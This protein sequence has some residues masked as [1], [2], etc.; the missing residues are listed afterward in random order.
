MIKIMLLVFLVS[1]SGEFSIG[2]PYQ[3]MPRE[4]SSLEE[5][6]AH[7]RQ[8]SFFPPPNG[9]RAVRYACEITKAI[10]I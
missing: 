10:D 9:F 4:Y 1:N 2:E 3:K 6:L 8:L 7:A 5:C